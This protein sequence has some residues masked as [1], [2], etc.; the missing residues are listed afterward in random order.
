MQS[1]QMREEPAGNLAWRP[2][3]ESAPG[4]AWPGDA[5]KRRGFMGTVK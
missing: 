4:P 1:V 2:L 3:L 5:V